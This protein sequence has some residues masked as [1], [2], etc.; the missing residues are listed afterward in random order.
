MRPMGVWERP[1]PLT[2]ADRARLA[3]QALQ[4]GTA[5]RLRELAGWSVDEMARACNV[6]TWRLALWETGDEAPA[7][8]AATK[9]WKVLVQACTAPSADTP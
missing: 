3:V 2:D 8:A 7:P 9:L 4:D 5:T 6:P 1:L